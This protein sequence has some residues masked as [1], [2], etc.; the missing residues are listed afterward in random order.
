[1]YILNS[2]YRIKVTRI[3]LLLMCIVS[4]SIF[5]E[6]GIRIPTLAEARSVNDNKVGVVF[7]HEELFHQLVHNMEDELEGDSGIRIV[8]IMGKNHV[9][10]VYDLLYLKG[11]DL[12]LLR[13]DA[14]EYVSRVGNYPAVKR[15]VHSIA[16]V[17]D[18]KI[19]IIAR[20]DYQTLNDLSG[21][22]VGYGEPGS[23]EYVTGTVAFS[24]LDI[25]PDVIEVNSNLA[26]EKIKSGELAAMIYLLRAPDAIQTGDDLRAANAV[27]NLDLGDDLHI[28]EIPETDELSE[29]YTPTALTSD[30]LPG[31]VAEDMTIPTYSVDAILATYRWIP[32]NFRHEQSRRFISAFVQGLDGLRSDAYQPIWKRVDL[33]LET[34]NI[35][36]SPLVSEVQEALAAEQIRLAEENRLAEQQAELAAQEARITEIMRKTDDLTARIGDE[37][38]NADEEELKLMLNRLNSILQDNQ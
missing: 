36:A 3:T 30:D 26:I 5:A 37:L 25:E 8:P 9:Q 6:S 7:T 2:H 15:V 16:K 33:D 10:S 38:V 18:E 20:K 29:I 17:S 21:Q 31:L 28:M 22:V 11:V 27:F 32:P 13:A 14:I 23:G 35:I 4:T 1:M 12:A 24:V 19:M 34:P